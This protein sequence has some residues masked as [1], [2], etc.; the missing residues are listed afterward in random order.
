[1]CSVSRIVFS[2]LTLA[3]LCAPLAASFVLAQT[4]VRSVKV[5]GS[6]DT[7]EVEVQAS[8]RIV[9]QTQV[10]TGPD[11][12]VID[13]ANAVPSSQLRSQSVNRGEVKDLRIGL[14]QA[15]PPVTR[16]VLDLKTAQSYQVFPNGRTVIIRVMG[17]SAN[18]SAAGDNLPAEPAKRPSLVAAN[19]T[20]RS[21]PVSMGSAAEP[22]L[23]VTYRD[24]L[25]GIRS[26]KAT[27]SEVLLAVQQ[28]TGAQVSVAPGAEQ[29]KVVVD[30]APGPAPEVMAR[31]LNG[32][33]FNFMILSVVDNPLQLDRVILS[34]RPDGA[35]MPLAPVPVPN[36]V[37]NE[38]AD[39]SSP[40][41][42]APQPGERPAPLPV[43]QPGDGKPPTEE[44]RPDI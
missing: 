29:E 12:L 33:K 5:L 4:S 37:P 35:I 34:T 26:N 14:F 3:A 15:K 36:Q 43:P 44:N 9:P 2:R 17:G 8:D 21:Q 31:L 19:Y 23:D 22:V 39:D 20:A 32:S 1:M 38:D 10:L 27:L 16:V 11:R 42:L 6:K 18:L 28:R 24:G 25:L 40:A 41:N 13:F 7:V 30:L